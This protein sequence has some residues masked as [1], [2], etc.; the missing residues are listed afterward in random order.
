V[1]RTLSLPMTLVD[2]LYATLDALAVAPPSEDHFLCHL[3]PPLDGIRWPMRLID[4]GLVELNRRIKEDVVASN[5]YGGDTL[6]VDDPT[7]PYGSDF[8]GEDVRMVKAMYLMLLL[9]EATDPAP[10][11]LVT[12]LYDLLDAL[13]ATRASLFQYHFLCH[14]LHQLDETSHHT[15]LVDPTLATLERLIMDDVKA[16]N[17]YGGCTLPLNEPDNVDSRMP[18]EDIR[19]VKAMYL[20]LLLAEVTDPMEAE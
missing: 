8:P 3:L 11:P 1:R 4:P 19:M 6:P 16:S 5:P 7:D 18:S 13:A 20:M 9:A 15:L 12:A 17:L 10:D 2:A 14:L